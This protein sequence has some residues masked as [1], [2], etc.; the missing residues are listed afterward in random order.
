[1][2]YMRML[3]INFPKEASKVTSS[4]I[5]VANFEVPYLNVRD[6]LDWN[7]SLPHHD[8]FSTKGDALL[9]ERYQEALEELE[10]DSRFTSDA[11]GTPILLLILS[12]PIYCF[13]F[14]IPYCG[15]L[16]SISWI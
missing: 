10:M 4:I 11:L 3:S 12:D 6:F 9:D 13:L 1:M 16:M 2:I 5:Q 14:I 7:N 8:Y 15:R